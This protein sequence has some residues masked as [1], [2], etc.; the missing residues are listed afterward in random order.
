M[1][2]RWL[3][4]LQRT[5][6]RIC[7]RQ[8]PE[9]QQHLDYVLAGGESGQFFQAYNPQLDYGNIRVEEGDI[10][11]QKAML[12]QYFETKG[13]EDEGFIEEMLNDYEDSGKLFSK[14]QVAQQEL[15]AIQDQQ[16]QQM[17]EMQ[18]EEYAQFQAE[19]EEFWGDVADVIE[20]G[21]EF[22]G[23]TIPD[24]EK[25][26]FFEYISAPVNERGA[27]ATRP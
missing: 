16:R 26:N 22:G 2:K 18:Q 11:V 25:A 19:Q 1:S 6:S 3:R 4:K 14:A 9:V 13:H 10:G 20:G 23:I 17:F 24:V 12:A 8:F 15:A 21:N 27:N 7:S 5:R